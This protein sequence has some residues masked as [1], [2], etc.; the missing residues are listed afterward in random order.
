MDP[1]RLT[2]DVSE[3]IPIEI[4]EIQNGFVTVSHRTGPHTDTFQSELEAADHVEHA[5][6]LDDE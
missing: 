1:A 2:A 6:C 3:P 5:T 4:E